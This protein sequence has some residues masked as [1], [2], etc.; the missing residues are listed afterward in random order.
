MKPIC[1][2]TPP[3]IFLLDERVFLTLG[4]LRVAAVLERAGR[5]VEMLDLSG[6]DGFETA[7]ADHA[8]K[9]EADTFGITATTPQLPATMIIARAI[10][11]VRPKAKIMLGGPHITLVNAAKKRE[12][13]LG[14][15]G[16]AHRAYESLLKVFDVLV[17]GDGEQAVFEALEPDAKG[18]VDADIPSGKLFLT[19]QTLEELPWPARHLVDVDSY[20]YSIDNERALSLI[21]QLGCPFA[22]GFCGGRESPML[23]RIR[24]RST[25]NIVGEIKHLYNRYG[26]RGIMF[27]DDEL[28]VN[29]KMI[30][31]MYAI[32]DL[33]SKLGVT[34]KLRGFI[35]SQLFTDQQAKAMYAA[36]FRW[37]LVGFE[38]GSERILDNMNKK[39]TRDENTRC[40][41]IATR[42]GLKV[43]ALMSIGHP[44]ESEQT[45]MDTRDW[46]LEVKPA[47]FDATVIT[48]Y[49]GT[50]YFDHALKN[51]QKEGIW[52]YEVT[53][54][55]DKLHSFD[56]DFENT[57]DYYKGK[58]G[59]YHAYVYTDYLQPDQL[60]ML[61]DKV[62]NEVRAKLGIPFNPGAPSI[63]YE[64]STGMSQLPPYILKSTCLP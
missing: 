21:A 26:A 6:I 17:A 24:T 1:L 9:S 18:L 16:R 10:R 59:D 50:P 30:E 62:E 32:G 36:G 23:R 7:A 41:E 51:P 61:R 3:S 48:T 31:L 37:I 13:T 42:A 12:T 55:G 8:A 15:H 47:D 57:A 14:Q 38:S 4:I 53:K 63:R 2:I 34:F 28:N 39:A 44:G 20:H 35:K 64:H 29:P 33:Q 60:V 49:P 5:T 43:K 40:M 56:V 58:L 27:Y 19:N 25:E 46:L 52:T 11:E 45:I 22:C 54:N